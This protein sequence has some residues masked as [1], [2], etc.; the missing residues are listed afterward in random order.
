MKM[1]SRHENGIAFFIYLL[2]TE[3]AYFPKKLFLQESNTVPLRQ[4]NNNYD[5]MWHVSTE[6]LMS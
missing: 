6:A 1:T 2:A 5:A 4:R 3:K